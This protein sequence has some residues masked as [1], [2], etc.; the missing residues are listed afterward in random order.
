M[1]KPLVKSINSKF[2]KQLLEFNNYSLNENVGWLY[3]I[4]G[5]DRYNRLLDINA[6]FS[7]MPRHDPVDR[8]Q[9]AVGPVCYSPERRWT[10]PQSEIS[11]ESALEK[12]VTELCQSNQTLNLMWSGGID[13][14]ALVVSFL[15]CAPDL[16]QC[17]IIY[18]PWS[19]F[20]HP[21]FFKFLKT[22]DNLELLDV[23]GEVYLTLDI[24]GLFISG[25]TSDEIHASLDE[26]FFTHYGYEFLFTPW[27]DFFYSNLPDSKFIDFCEEY[28]AYSGRDINTVLDAR[29]WFY[30]STKLTGLLNDTNLAFLMS[31][32][33]KFDPNRLVGFYDCDVYEQFIYF[34]IDKIIP[35]DNYSTWRQ[36]LKDYC[37]NYDGFDD[38]RINKSKFSS[39]QLSIYSEKKECLNDSRHLMLLDNGVRVSTP[40]LPLFSQFDW[41]Q[42]KQNY[43]HVFRTPNSV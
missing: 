32:P 42:I 12:R 8:C 2:A 36:F 7:T 6:M 21:E 24:D 3:K 1:D 20:E 25:H 30:A 33:S 18:S 5:F 37:Y 28:F 43:Q 19:T 22:F 13:S 16:R 9:F 10:I 15:K 23:S 35:S 39:N 11:L 26:S 40:N 34:N 29:W 14:T 31:G 27:K 38:W 41:D 4:E 17:R